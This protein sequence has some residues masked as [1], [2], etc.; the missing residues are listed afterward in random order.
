MKVRYTAAARADTDQ[1]LALIR[2]DNPPAAGAVAAA[3]KAAVVRLR[4]FP[5]IGAETDEPGVYIK[6][7][8]PY[9]YLI[10]YRVTYNGVVIRNVRHPARHRPSS[11]RS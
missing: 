10:F 7:V 6:I 9:R 5:F 11:V 3:I 4:S 2:R 1:I 8:R